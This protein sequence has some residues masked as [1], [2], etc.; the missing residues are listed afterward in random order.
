M[1]RIRFLPIGKEIRVPEGT[2][3]NDAAHQAGIMIDLPCGGKGTCG[4]CIVR[5][6]QGTVASKPTSQSIDAR[7]ASGLMLACQSSINTD[8]TVRIQEGLAGAASDSIDDGIDQPGETEL[9]A[10]RLTPLSR[11][12]CVQVQRPV[13][14]DGLSDIDRVA[15][16]LRS[17]LQVKDIACSLPVIRKTA[18]ALREDDGWVTVTLSQ[19]E[20]EARIINIKGGQRDC[21][22]LGI[23]VDLGTTTIS[24]RMIDCETGK[25]LASKNGYNDQ[26]HCGLDVISRINYAASPERLEDLRSR[27]VNSINRLI[28]A[29]VNDTLARKEDITACR[30]SGNTVMSHLFL[31]LK[32]EYIR[33]DPYTPTLMQI[34]CFLASDLG[35]DILPEAIVTFSPCVG[36]YVGGDITAGILVTDLAKDRDEICVFIDIGTNGEIVVGNREFLMTCACSAGPAF[37]GGGIDCGM[38]ASTGAIDHATVDP[39]TGRAKYTV[40]GGGKPVGLCGSGLIDLVAELHIAGWIDPSG[41]FSREKPSRFISIAGRRASYTVV[42]GKHSSSGKPII[43]SETDIENLMRAKAAIYSATSL[44]LQQAGIHFQGI[45]TFSVAGGFGRYLD[46]S[47]AMILGLLPDIPAEKFRYIGNASLQGSGLCLLSEEF[48]KRQA[49]LS[50][51]MTYI[52]LS[53]FPGYMDQYTAALFLP[54]TDLRSFPNVMKKLNSDIPPSR[55]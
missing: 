44:L 24:V 54:H 23:A 43:I 41:K 17:L 32:P 50:K 29:A 20:D 3:I 1:P 34:P 45:S 55:D 46:I 7:T 33:L 4:K 52:D 40:I 42:E 6:S 49:A 5:V 15:R 27:A 11:Q 38:R 36:S 37:E 16:G 53:A 18:D 14:E 8:V 26:I 2:L 39:Q 21:R 12:V 22:N 47:H 28:L 31:A 25:V 48:R 19:E 51:R 30:I 13:K 10:A 9:E 35:L